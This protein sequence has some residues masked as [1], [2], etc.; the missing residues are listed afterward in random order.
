[1]PVIFPD[2]LKMD[3]TG[4]K[5]DMEWHFSLFKTQGLGQDSNPDQCRL[6]AL[7]TRHPPAF[8]GCKEAHENTTEIALT[9]PSSH[10]SNSEEK[11]PAI[12][13]MSLTFAQS[14]NKTLINEEYTNYQATPKDATPEQKG[15]ITLLIELAN[16]S[17]SCPSAILHP[18]N[19][20]HPPKSLFPDP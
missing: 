19:P 7:K 15:Y 1:M 6:P 4:F 18:Q 8:F 12:G 10:W 13:L 5:K 16:E 9:E 2:L 3:L 14:A 17:L 20:G 11:T